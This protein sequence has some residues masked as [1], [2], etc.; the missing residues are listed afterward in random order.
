MINN[1]EVYKE[2]NDMSKAKSSND[3]WDEIIDSLV[4]ETEPPTKYIKDAIIV[5]KNGSSYRVSANDFADLCAREK[6]IPPEQS[7]IQHCSVSIDFTRIKRDVNKWSLALIESVEK[8]FPSI[9]LG[10]KTS[11]A[12]KSTTKKTAL[13]KVAVVKKRKVD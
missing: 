7:E 5:T 4:L 2:V 11:K 10:S 8:G 12:K 9:D 3:I 1:N 6:M 13:K